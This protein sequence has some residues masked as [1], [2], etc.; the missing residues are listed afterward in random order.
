MAHW[1][2][3]MGMETNM[4]TASKTSVWLLQPKIKKQPDGALGIAN[5][6]G[7]KHANSKQNIGL[8]PPTQDQEAARWRIGHR[9][10]VWKQTCQQQAKHRSGS[11]NPRSRSSQM[12]HWASQMGM[13]TNMPTASKT[14]V[15]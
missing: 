13:E 15:W 12:A 3:Q 1:A 5:G 8:A 6:Y 7:N 11:S 14:S 9:K 2:S 4:P 10:W